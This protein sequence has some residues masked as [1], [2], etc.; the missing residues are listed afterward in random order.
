MA[1]CGPRPPGRVDVK[2]STRPSSEYPGALLSVLGVVSRTGSPPV[3]GTIHTSEC[4]LFSA[5]RT[6]V[7][8]KATFFPSGDSAGALTFVTLYQSAGVN[9]CRATVE[10]GC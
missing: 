6:V 1:H 7:T 8:V 4:R 9:A 3:S 10:E 5:S 2:Y